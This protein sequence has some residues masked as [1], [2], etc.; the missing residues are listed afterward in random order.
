LK[1]GG[2]GQHDK[3]YIKV[4][5]EKQ[6]GMFWRK[7]L[8]NLH[9]STLAGTWYKEMVLNGD[10]PPSETRNRKINSSNNV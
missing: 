6:I 1:G 7:V 8:E 2:I 4:F 10:K 9:K 3:R 5:G